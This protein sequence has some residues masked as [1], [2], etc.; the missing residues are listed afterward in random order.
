MPTKSEMWSW[1]LTPSWFKN[2]KWTKLALNQDNAHRVAVER[3]ADSWKILMTRWTARRWS[4]PNS[5]DRREQNGCRCALGNRNCCPTFLSKEGWSNCWSALMLHG[6]C[7]DEPPSRFITLTWQLDG[8]ILECPSQFH[9]ALGP[10]GI[11]GPGKELS[12]LSKRWSSK[13][14]THLHC[15]K[16]W[17]Q[18]SR[19]SGIVVELISIAQWYR[20]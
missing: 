7:R 16:A 9:V 3:V 11:L 10:G 17:T 12:K 4:L 13:F 15:Y 6:I 19:I 18:D 20:L 1:S 14:W 5:G 2:H 8:I